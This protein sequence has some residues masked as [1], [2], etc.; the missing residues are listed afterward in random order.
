M[1]DLTS[2][3]LKKRRSSKTLAVGDIF[4]AKF[5]AWS[6]AKNIKVSD[7]GIARHSSAMADPKTPLSDQYPAQPHRFSKARPYFGL[8]VQHPAVAA[9]V[10]GPVEAG[11]GPGDEVFQRIAP[12]GPRRAQRNS[13]PKKRCVLQL[14]PAMF[15]QETKPFGDF[16][17]GFGRD[18]GADEDEL[19]APPADGGI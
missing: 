5:F 8:F 12:A 14:Q 13:Y 10:L 2:T 18:F 7:I 19:L 4:P 16:A 3:R 15:H 11:V 17:Q 1:P 9:R 6:T